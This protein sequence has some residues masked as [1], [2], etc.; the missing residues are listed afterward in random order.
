MKDY[1]FLHKKSVGVWGYVIY[2]SMSFWTSKFVLRFQHGDDSKWNV[3][4]HRRRARTRLPADAASSRKQGGREH[5]SRRQL[6][7]GRVATKWAAPWRCVMTVGVVVRISSPRGL[8]A[9]CVGRSGAG[10]G[11]RLVATKLFGAGW[12]S[13][14]CQPA[15]AP[16]RA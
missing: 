11:K 9:F 3:G 7:R 8:P 16:A 6:S 14:C 10:A 13:S 2:I 12:P 1:Y 15:R 5:D 4:W